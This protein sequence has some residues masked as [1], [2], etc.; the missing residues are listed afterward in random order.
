MNA[1]D[2]EKIRSLISRS[3]R[4]EGRTLTK[5]QRTHSKK[6]RIGSCSK[7]SAS[8]NKWDFLKRSFYVYWFG[9]GNISKPSC[10]DVINSNSNALKILL[11]TYDT[12]L[13][14][15]NSIKE[16]CKMIEVSFNTSI[17]QMMDLCALITGF[18][19]Y[20]HRL[21]NMVTIEVLNISSYKDQ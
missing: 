9:G 20:M 1:F 18:L 15:T 2:L 6:L 21:I 3:K 4:Q 8:S 5:L 14:C 12:L 10:R 13:N 17:T 19:P 7:F 16:V 11:S